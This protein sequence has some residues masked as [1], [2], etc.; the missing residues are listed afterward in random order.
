MLTEP[1]PVVLLA[2]LPLVVVF[3]FWCSVFPLVP[4]GRCESIPF[5]RLDRLGRMISCSTPA[6]WVYIRSD[7]YLLTLP[8]GLKDY[9]VVLR[10]LDNLW[11]CGLVISF[12]SWFL[13]L[14]SP[15]SVSVLW[16]SGMVR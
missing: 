12:G 1:D 13:R 6:S 14:P 7:Q 8:S 16:S 15:G 4:A 9:T 11:R 2:A 5:L 3:A 10:T